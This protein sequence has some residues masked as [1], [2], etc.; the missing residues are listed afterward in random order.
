MG[1][2]EAEATEAESAELLLSSCSSYLGSTAL[3]KVKGWV[4]RMKDSRND[5]GMTPG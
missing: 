2:A 5:A 3:A 4:S 1:C